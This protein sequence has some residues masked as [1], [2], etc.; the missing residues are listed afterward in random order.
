M[1]GDDPFDTLAVRL[2][3]ALTTVPVIFFQ[4]IS[5]KYHSQLRNYYYLMMIWV[6]PI[7]WGLMLSLNAAMAPIESSPY[8][9]FWALQYCAGI[10]IYSQ[11]IN[12]TLLSFA[13]WM[14]SVIIVAGV[15][16]LNVKEPNLELLS[17]FYLGPILFG[18]AAIIYAGSITSSS[19]KYSQ[20][21][22]LA[23]AEMMSAQLA[24][25]MRT[26]LTGVSMRANAT[27]KHLKALV[28]V[29]RNSQEQRLTKR[30]LELI[31][32]SC[33]DI[34]EE[35]DY[36]DALIDMLLHT[37]SSRGLRENDLA[38]MD[39][40]S[41]ITEALERY[42]FRS[43]VERDLVTHKIMETFVIRGNKVLLVH[44]LFNLIKNAIYYVQRSPEGKIHIRTAIVGNIGKV[45][46]EDSGPGI[47]KENLNRIFERFF[48]TTDSKH[49]TGIGLHF[50]SSVMEDIGGTIEATSTPNIK[51]TFTLNFPIAP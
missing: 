10:Y 4:D 7:T 39:V 21:E 49:G 26:P 29:Y 30:Q 51:T 45:H 6:F 38:S 46:I 14:S 32:D 2:F 50:C 27:A 42:P 22:S 36:A 31:K 33:R 37:T 5:R 20:K 44:V 13:G 47:P 8:M 40:D 43:S 41:L 17:S 11:L 24:H 48:S 25:Q 12:S 35:A 1:A 3:A 18:Y 19:P 15:V 16:F 23:A 9:F 34:V 28:D